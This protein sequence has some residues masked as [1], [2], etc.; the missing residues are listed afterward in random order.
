MLVNH[1]PRS[2]VSLP[3]F[4]LFLANSFS[5]F[6]SSTI[7]CLFPAENILQTNTMQDINYILIKFGL[8]YSFYC[9]IFHCQKT[10]TFNSCGTGLYFIGC[11]AVQMYPKWMHQHLAVTCSYLFSKVLTRASQQ[12]L[13]TEY[14]EQIKGRN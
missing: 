1:D 5:I 10:D 7:T 2:F 11:F 3:T 8:K 14:L 13:I 9:H 4:K 12:L 6:E